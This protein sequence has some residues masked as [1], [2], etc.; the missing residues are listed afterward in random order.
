MLPPV[1]PITNSLAVTNFQ[2]KNR[3][4][5]AISQSNPCTVTTFTPHEFLNNVIIKFLIP[6]AA[7]M[8]QLKDK[9]FPIT[10][11]GPVTFTIPIDSTSFQ[12]FVFLGQYAQFPAQANPIAERNRNLDSAEDNVPP[13]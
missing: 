2:P 13:F 12:P 1:P 6:Q 7:G 11:T 10:V 5:F 8:S 9:F 4:I 3:I